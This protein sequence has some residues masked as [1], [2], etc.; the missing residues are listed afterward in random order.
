MD[1]TLGIEHN[2]QALLRVVARLAAMVGAAKTLPRHLHRAALRLLRPAEWAA[3]RLVIAVARGVAPPPARPRKPASG[4][5]L[6]RADGI[7]VLARPAFVK[8]AASAA[9]EKP[10]RPLVLPLFDPLPGRPRARPSLLGTPR[11][12]VPDGTALFPVAARLPL[13]SYDQLDAARI[14]LRIAALSDA[15]QDLPRHALRYA[16]WAGRPRAA[17]ARPGARRGRTHRV[18]PLRTWRLPGKRSAPEV[19]EIVQAAQGLALWALRPPDG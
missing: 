12:S 3:R 13:R 2:R 14:G 11:I 18:W 8:Q 10:L 7:V 5:A 1:G 4:L 9:R 6:L 15:L 19:H 17:P 16:R